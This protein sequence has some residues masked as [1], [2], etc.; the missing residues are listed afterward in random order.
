[1]QDLR[2][3]LEELIR[4]PA[5]VKSFEVKAREHIRQHYSWERVAGNTEAVYLRLLGG[6]GRRS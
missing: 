4:D 3:K 6:A 1:M 2:A 5:R